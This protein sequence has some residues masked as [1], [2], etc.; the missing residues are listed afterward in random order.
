[1][2]IYYLVKL[3]YFAQTSSVGVYYLSYKPKFSNKFSAIKL[4]HMMIKSHY[5]HL[6]LQKKN[7]TN[8]HHCKSN[9]L[10]YENVLLL[11]NC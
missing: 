9:I 3:L 1:M 6:C 2:Y 5:K 11:L 4:S 10:D 8:N 7:K